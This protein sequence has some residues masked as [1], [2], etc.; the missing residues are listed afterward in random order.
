MRVTNNMMTASLLYN[1]N[2]NLEYMSKKQDELATGKKIHAP[3]DDPVLASK[4]LARRT[5]LSELEQYS[6]NTRDALGWMEITEKAI[7]DN[8]N[9][10]QKVRELTVQAANGSNTPSD[11][12]KIMKEIENIREQLVTN[13]NSTFA[14]R[15]IFSGFETNQKLL[16][17]DGTFNIDI[18]KYSM[19]NKPVVKYEVGVGESID[20]MTSGLDIYGL[21]ETSNIMTSGFTS[22]TATGTASSF[23]YLQG[24]LN[25]S[26][27]HSGS[28]FDIDVAGT[29]YDVDESLLDGTTSYLSEEDVIEVYKKADDGSGNLLGDVAEMSFDSDGNFTIKSKVGGAIVMTP[30]SPV[31]FLAAGNG[32]V[33]VTGVDVVEVSVTSAAY[34]DPSLTLGQSAIDLLSSKAIKLDYNGQ[35][36]DLKPRDTAVF[37]SLN[38][39]VTEMNVVFDKAFGPGKLVMAANATGNISITTQNTEAEVQPSLSVDFP[40]YKAGFPSGS[41]TGASATRS[42]LSAKIIFGDDLSGTNLDVTVAGTSY[43]VTTTDL[44][45]SL[46][47]FTKEDIIKAYEN[48]DDGSGNLL[49]S[50]ANIYFNSADRLVIEMDAFGPTAMTADAGGTHFD[51]A[52][53]GGTY[54][55]TAVVE[56]SVSGLALG[57][58][59][60]PMLQADIDAL[61]DNPLNVVFNSLSRK[62][63]PAA[64]S[65]IS[66][67]NDY[68]SEMNTQFDKE[69]GAGKLVMS[70]DA[71]GVITIASV[72]STNAQVPEITV[73]FERSHKS[74][75]MADIDELLGYLQAGDHENISKMLTTVDKHMSNMLS[76]RADIGARTNRMELIGKKIASNNISF[77]Q[78]LSDAEDA[79]MSE[80]IML[81][82]NAENV[83]QASLSTGARIIQPSLVDFLR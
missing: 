45:G 66:T 37:T 56:A 18:D 41:D 17:D 24:T 16:N 46:F 63:E 75:M 54:T 33:S 35:K 53:G 78:L 4:V 31:T 39:Y 29:V 57:D 43:G 11:T 44:N 69:F 51:V 83:Y 68:V 60:L 36:I 10:F 14:G 26:N 48:A 70:A 21:V 20:V 13:A 61:R 81:L 32:G 2:K 79:D 15:Y 8:G 28:N 6:K 30:Q 27:D 47:E 64:T 3:S 40:N 5:D 23:S 19:D 1:V 73:D 80:V 55:G 25:R 50:I 7:E 49:G 9:L 74:E 22:T 12:Q 76:L 71:Q 82:K 77:T 42:N 58:P 72:G 34:G 52:N 59:T 62:I 38:A 67:L 65:T